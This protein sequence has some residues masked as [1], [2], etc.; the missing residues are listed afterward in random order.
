MQT[1][2]L[3]EL[4]CKAVHRGDRLHVAPGYH[5]QAGRGARTTFDVFHLGVATASSA[6]AG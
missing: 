5:H 6:S 4:D 2:V 1:K 3:F